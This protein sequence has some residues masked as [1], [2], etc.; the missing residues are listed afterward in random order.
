MLVTEIGES[1]EL[2][3]TYGL[4]STQSVTVSK[5]SV[6]DRMVSQ[7]LADAS[8][9]IFLLLFCRTQ[10]YEMKHERPGQREDLRIYETHVGISSWEG[11]VASYRHFIDEVL[12]R[13]QDLGIQ[14]SLS[15]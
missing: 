14:Y 7:L 1:N 11:K 8:Y 4:S 10:K 9:N 15:V 5:Q 12:P 3:D 2:E 6:Q 13:V